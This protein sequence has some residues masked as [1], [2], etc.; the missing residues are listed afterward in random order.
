[1]DNIQ[2]RN[3]NEPEIVQ[4]LLQ[5]DAVGLSTIALAPNTWF[6]GGT[7]GNMEM[8]DIAQADAVA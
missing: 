5:G 6:G 8:W 4:D 7:A 3:A 2:I 1:M